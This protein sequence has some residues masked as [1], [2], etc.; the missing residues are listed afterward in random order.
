MRPSQQQRHKENPQWHCLRTTMNLPLFDTTHTR[1]LLHVWWTTPAQP[2]TT[3]TPPWIKRHTHALVYDCQKRSHVLP[4]Y[5]P[6][7]LQQNGFLSLPGPLSVF[8]S[9]PISASVDHFN[10]VCA[11]KGMTM[12]PIIRGSHRGCSH[13]WTFVCLCVQDVYPPPLHSPPCC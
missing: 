13:A 5:T 8:S 3:T 2:T 11:H 4:L 9:A 7:V 1:A 6:P 10:S 12:P